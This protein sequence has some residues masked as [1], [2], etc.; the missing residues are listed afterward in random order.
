MC[1][2]HPNQIVL[3]PFQLA[4]NCASPAVFRN[5]PCC[6]RT[7]LDNLVFLYKKYLPDLEL[8]IEQHMSFSCPIFMLPIHYL[9]SIMFPFLIVLAIPKTSYAYIYTEPLFDLCHVCTHYKI[10]SI[11]SKQLL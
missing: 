9:H 1:M 6:S 3:R 10:K 2:F 5:M 4:P 7:I 8:L 11:L